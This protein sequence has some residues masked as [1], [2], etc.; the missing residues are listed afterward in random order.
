M[1][2]C[3]LCKVEMKEGNF[4]QD[5]KSLR[6]ECKSCIKEKRRTYYILNRLVIID[7]VKEHYRKNKDKIMDYKRVYWNTDVFKENRRNR[8]H[9]RR[10]IE[11]DT[12]ITSKHL[13]DLKSNTINCPCCNIKMIKT[14]NKPD[15]ITIDHIIPI[16]CGG[17]HMKDNIRMICRQCNLERPKDGRDI[18]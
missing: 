8:K 15:S 5:G 1:K 11:K 13:I 6:G 12:D 7:N 3:S 4:Y 2:I 14:P 10:T 9:L 17:K 16:G 18:K